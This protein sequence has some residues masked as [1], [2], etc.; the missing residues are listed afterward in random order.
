MNVF[1]RTIG[2]LL[3]LVT[4]SLAK[5]YVV[6]PVNGSPFEAD[7]V[8]QSRDS[9]FTRGEFGA[10]SFIWSDLLEIIEPE[11]T[12]LPRPDIAPVPG[13]NPVVTSPG[14]PAVKL[15]SMKMRPYANW[16]IPSAVVM[17][18]GVYNVFQSRSHFNRAN[19]LEN[20]GEDPAHER[21]V[22]EKMR[23]FGLAAA[24]I[25]AAGIVF[26]LTPKEVHKPVFITLDHSGT[27]WV[28]IQYEIEVL[29]ILD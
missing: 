6:Y 9:V 20:A 10:R 23:G 17:G 2:T 4:V 29:G 18:F 19:E 22:G 8:F 7:S 24:F 1:Y 26:A 13:K 16:V 15:K 5:P 21:S 11:G 12:S 14:L 28:G 27:T 25:G 3:V